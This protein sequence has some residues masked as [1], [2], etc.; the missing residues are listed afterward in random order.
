MLRILHDKRSSTYLKS[1]LLLNAEPFN[2]VIRLHFWIQFDLVT[3]KYTLCSWA[4][5]DCGHHEDVGVICVSE[6]DFTDASQWEI[7]LVGSVLPSQ[8]M[9]VVRPKTLVPPLW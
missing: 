9:V 4:M 2:T 1:C 3:N 8:G 6:S 7:G 5:S